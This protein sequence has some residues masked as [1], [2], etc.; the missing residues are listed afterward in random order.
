M[1]RQLAGQVIAWHTSNGGFCPVQGQKHHALRLLH[2]ATELCLA[3]GA[4]GD[5]VAEVIHDEVVKHEERHGV[6][7]VISL[8]GMRGE[9]AD[10][11]ILLEILAVHSEAVIDEVVHEKLHILHDRKWIVD[12]HGV[13][14]RDRSPEGLQREPEEA[15]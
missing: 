1:D 7:P 5:E 12:Q 3:S 14:W 6:A 2:E 8:A 4:V 9:I 13:L 10:V 15:L 11:A